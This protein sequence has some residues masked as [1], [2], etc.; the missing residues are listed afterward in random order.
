MSE[1]MSEKHQVNKTNE[2]LG[3]I[4]LLIAAILG[5]AYYIPAVNTGP[6]GMLLLNLGKGLVG[7]VAYAFPVLFLILSIT[8][9]L[10]TIIRKHKIR[11]NHIFLILIL[12]ASLCHALTVEFSWIAE[13]S[14]DE[15]GNQT[16]FKT[17]EV[18]WK[19]S[20]DPSQ[21][22]SLAT[23]LPGGVLGGLVALGLQRVTGRF[24][25]NAILITAILA[26]AV[27]LGNF[28]IERILRGI[29]AF[30]GFIFRG[31]G[32][33]VESA[34]SALY[35][36]TS[37]KLDD[38]EDGREPQRVSQSAKTKKA[39]FT[40][41]PP[42][43][44]EGARFQTSIERGVES[45]PPS[46]TQTPA[47]KSRA[48]APVQNPNPLPNVASIPIDTYVIPPA[49]AAP[50]ST[51]PASEPVRSYTTEGFKAPDF[52][53]LD[54]PTQKR[55]GRTPVKQDFLLKSDEDDIASDS[56]ATDEQKRRFKESALQAKPVKPVAVPDILLVDEAKAAGAPSSASATEAVRASLDDL[57]NEED[58]PEEVDDLLA[59]AEV[60][61]PYE[62][63][64]ITLLEPRPVINSTSNAARIHDLAARLE[65][66]L[67]SFGVEAKV[68]HITTGPSITRFE[69]R[70]GVGVKIS[71]IVGLGDDIALSLAAMAVRIEAPIPGKSAIGIEIPNPETAIVGLRSLIEAEDYQTRKEKL[72][73]PLGRDI[74]GQPIYCDLA[75]MPHLLIAGA[76]G[77]GKSISINTILVSL[78]YRNSPQELKLILIDPKV[79][80]LSVYNGIPHLMAP[81][82][83]DPKKAAN[84]LNWAV[85]EMTRRYQLFAEQQVRDMKG[86]NE[87]ADTRGYEKLP[88]VVI[89]IDELSDLMAVSANEVEDSI[90]RLTAMARAAGIHLIIATQRPSVD[91]I[92]GVIKANVPSRLAFAVASQVDSRTILDG[93][94]AEKLLG[95]GD[96]LYSPQSSSKPTRGQGAYVSD[97]EVENIVS[98]LKAQKL[99]AF[100]KEEAEE[101]I[102]TPTPGLDTGGSSEEPEEDDLLDEAVDVVLDAG[103]ASV[104]VW[105]RRLN[106]G[107]PRAGRLID[108]ME[109]KGYIGPFVG[110]KPRQ[111]LLTRTD[112]ALRNAQNQLE[113]RKNDST[114]Y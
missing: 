57:A 94:G 2:I 75:K 77:S 93:G 71:K 32:R 30:L 100:D 20:Q 95:K 49:G 104:S 80:E 23:S 50:A 101:I 87:D 62:F 26:E 4:Y 91:V 63:P 6:L 33:A 112:W 36:L 92:T 82:V 113:E 34:S 111:V 64:P 103:Y 18:L 41:E 84:T 74:P 83:T 60:E 8:T 14:R 24:G 97:H 99:K 38:P 89:I 55:E 28:S 47:R 73:V 29:A 107:Y 88:F 51:K 114:D 7:P 76:T 25:A 67:A 10:H 13:L 39:E 42:F 17:F 9:F 16:V 79:V 45:G 69:L 66:T 54:E 108:V 61:K 40:E 22:E 35:D 98:F 86:Y 78:L 105:Q 70:P 5:V 102:N 68:V 12:A 85:N 43:R 19:A 31:V 37:G 21:Y 58:S 106:I 109:M 56:T 11:I 96:M 59:L 46:A 65:A 15:A 44:R 110:S 52:L 72:L 3:L 53:L 81:V 48:Q 90:S 1:R 27:V